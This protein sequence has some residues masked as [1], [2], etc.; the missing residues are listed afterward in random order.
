M[1]KQSTL[2]STLQIVKILCPAPAAHDGAL[3]RLK[4]MDFIALHFAGTIRRHVALHRGRQVQVR[5]RQLASH[6]LRCTVCMA[7]GTAAHC[8][9][10]L[11]FLVCVLPA[12]VQSCSH[13]DVQRSV[14]QVR[15][16]RHESAAK[17]KVRKCQSH[18]RY[19]SQCGKRQS[20]GSHTQ[21]ANQARRRN[22]CLLMLIAVVCSLLRSPVCS[23]PQRRAV[24]AYQ[25][26]AAAP[27]DARV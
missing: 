10:S 11:P 23:G 14:R 21:T 24:S 1:S 22:R 15:R 27:A 8:C 3:R 13:D 5:M 26:S 6:S 19:R 4:R 2:Q 7:S 25:P 12:L 17:R 9:D 16:T 18:Y 20:Q